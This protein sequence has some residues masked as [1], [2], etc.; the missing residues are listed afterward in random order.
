[1]KKASNYLDPEEKTLKT[2]LTEPNKNSV[3]SR[4]H[5]YL[6]NQKAENPIEEGRSNQNISKYM[7]LVTARGIIVAAKPTTTGSSKRL[8]IITQDCFLE[9]YTDLSGKQT[10]PNYS[11]PP[12]SP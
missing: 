3:K 7:V 6:H 12:P 11:K 10:N 2:S 4:I 5:E 1:M 9:P 8:L